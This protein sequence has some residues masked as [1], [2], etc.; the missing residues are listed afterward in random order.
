V[1]RVAVSAYWIKVETHRNAT[2]TRIPIIRYAPTL[3]SDLRHQLISSTNTAKRIDSASLSFQTTKLN[4]RPKLRVTARYVLYI[5]LYSVA[6]G[7]ALRVPLSGGLSLWRCKTTADRLWL[8][9]EKGGSWVGA[10]SGGVG[11]FLD[12]HWDKSLGAGCTDRIDA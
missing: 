6:S 3:T 9:K 12:A 11:K 10:A 1:I 5:Q 7:S 4:R 2:A 8:R